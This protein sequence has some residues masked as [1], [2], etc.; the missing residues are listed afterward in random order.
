MIN[1]T[2]T[3]LF[4]RS[5][6]YNIAKKHFF[7]KYLLNTNFIATKDK[8]NNNSPSSAKQE[9]NIS[10]I[11]L[12][13]ILDEKNIKISITDIL[14]DYK[15]FRF[16]YYKQDPSDYKY[17]LKIDEERQELMNQV[18]LPFNEKNISFKNVY[19]YFIFQGDKKTMLYKSVLIIL[20]L[21]VITAYFYYSYSK[22]LELIVI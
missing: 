16:R 17:E 9:Q 8:A 10:K 13:D 19:K 15:N 14:N 21:H 3:T 6:I 12:H 18:K 7:I 20:W 11:D 2:T 5:P 1:K 22:K 4:K